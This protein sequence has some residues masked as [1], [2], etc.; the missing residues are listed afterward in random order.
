M[1]APPAGG[2]AESGADRLSRAGFSRRFLFSGGTAERRLG[3]LSR[4]AKRSQRRRPS[5]AGRPASAVA[6]SAKGAA[7]PAKPPPSPRRWSFRLAALLLPLLLL[8]GLEV[9]LRVAHYGYPTTFFLEREIQG[10]PRLVEND[11][12]GWRFFPRELARSPAPLAVTRAKPEGVFRI[13]LFGESAALG[14]PRPA[15]GMGPHLQAL[16]NER[17]PAGRFEVIPLA[18]TAINSYALELM[19]RE[20]VGLDADL[21]IVYAGN[22]ELMGPFGASGVLGATAPPRWLVRAGLAFKATK[23][24]QWIEDLLRRLNPP[25]PDAA[26]GGLK[27]FQEHRVPPDDPA[28]ARVYASF[29]ANL[30]D[31]V[32]IGTDAGVEVLLCTVASNLRDSSPFAS[33]APP[34]PADGSPPRWELLS[35]QASRAA[36]TND[37]AGA[38]ARFQEAAALATNHAQ[39]RFSLAQCELALSNRPAARTNFVA[40]RDLDALPFRAD[41]RINAAIRAVARKLAGRGARF[42]DAAAALDQAATNGIAGDDLFFEHVHFNLHGNYQMARALAERI[43]PRLPAAVKKNARPHWATPE[44]CAHRLGLTDWNRAALLD[45]ALARMRDAPFTNR[46]SHPRNVARLRARRREVRARLEPARYF[47]ARAIYEEALR[48]APDNARIHENFAEFLEANGEY[49]E[50]LTHWQAMARLWPHHYLPKF[51]V[52]RALIHLRRYDEARTALNAALAQRPDFLEARLQLAAL[53]RAE[54]RNEEALAQYDALLA[55]APRNGRLHM[56]R[57]DLLAAVGR[58]AE[59]VEELR[60]AIRANPGLWKAHYLLG[61]ELALKNQLPEA[62]REFRVAVRERPDFPLAHFNL[63]IALVR[64]GY[65]GEARAQ[66]QATLRLDPDNAQA[67]KSLDQLEALLRR[68]RESRSGGPSGAPPR[69]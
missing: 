44:R 3:A 48:H 15:Y 1:P 19:A 59:A 9:G 58:R 69:P 10:R 18:M 31:L 27:M 37:W 32:R 22:N 40:A 55:R 54:G 26:W 68:Y 28:R 35:R 13:L 16:L 17:Y 4:R 60:A 47:D 30:E 62:T 6:A 39:I 57:A 50:A 12:F 21:W 2:K 49:E 65:V 66:F 14:D 46:L 11:R 34:A 20:A 24:G 7:A 56:E 38:R 33:A 29:R 51:Y 42:F 45:T 36:R 8:A 67:R 5:R 63:G 23:T 41:S 53:F 43:A 61:V 64:Q 52:G 25:P